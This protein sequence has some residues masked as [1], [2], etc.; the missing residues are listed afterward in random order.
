MPRKPKGEK[1]M[2]GAERAKAHRAKK[3]QLVSAPLL[4]P[5]AYVSAMAALQAAWEVADEATRDE[6]LDTVGS[7]FKPDPM[8]TPVVHTKPRALWRNMAAPGSL[9]KGAK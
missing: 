9:L 7:G 5:Q 6:F 2:T 8:D 4:P 3:G 1:P